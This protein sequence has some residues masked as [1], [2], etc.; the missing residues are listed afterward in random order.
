M[1][2]KV[3]LA[4]LW[5]RLRAIAGFRV[6]STPLDE[7]VAIAQTDIEWLKRGF[8]VLVAVI[9]ARPYIP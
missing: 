3:T 7:K 9:I 8:W 4:V 5:C 2:G 1:A 6:R